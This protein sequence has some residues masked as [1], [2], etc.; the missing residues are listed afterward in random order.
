MIMGIQIT[1]KSVCCNPRQKK[2]L[3]PQTC[4][5]NTLFLECQTSC[6]YGILLPLFLTPYEHLPHVL[7][8]LVFLSVLPHPAQVVI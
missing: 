4:P 8:F 7:H 1:M 2:I 6:S 3:H 5:H